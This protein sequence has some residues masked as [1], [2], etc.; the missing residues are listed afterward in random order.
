MFF[1]KCLLPTAR[2]GTVLHMSVCSQS[3]S[4]LLGYCSS[5]LLRGWYASYWNA[6]LSIIITARKRSLGQGNMFTPVCHSVHRGVPGPGGFWSWGV[7]GGEPPLWAVYILLE[8][9]LVKIKYGFCTN[10]LSILSHFFPIL[11]D[12]L[13]IIIYF[14]QLLYICHVSFNFLLY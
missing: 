11:H 14:I 12:V 6:V 3:A 8:C 13:I 1:A 5:L 9:I 10:V 4:W 7:P 2:E